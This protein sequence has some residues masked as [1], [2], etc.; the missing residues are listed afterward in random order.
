MLPAV[1]HFCG[2][3]DAGEIC[4][5][6]RLSQFRCKLPPN[7]KPS[8]RWSYLIPSLFPE[9]FILNYPLH[10]RLLITVITRSYRQG[11]CC[12]IQQRLTTSTYRPCIWSFCIC[13]F[14]PT[15]QHGPVTC[16]LTPSR[17][18]R[19][20]SNRFCHPLSCLPC[21]VAPLL[22]STCR[23]ERERTRVKG[24][25]DAIN[26][27]NFCG[28]HYSIEGWEDMSTGKKLLFFSVAFVIYFWLRVCL[29]VCMCVKKNSARQYGIKDKYTNM[30]LNNFT[31]SGWIFFKLEL[32]ICAWHCLFW[33]WNIVHSIIKLGQ[34]SNHHAHIFSAFNVDLSDCFIWF[35]FERL[36]KKKTGWRMQI[37]DWFIVSWLPWLINC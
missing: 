1:S 10:P 13:L 3:A 16:E 8:L 32:H 37:I 2:T 35:S 28:S 7:L 36:T 23:S 9:D 33:S 22:S 27:C 31:F 5:H 25:L 20:P 26:E 17:S 11:L 19:S 29:R 14:P 21:P 18:P 15:E 4:T 6:Q 24:G 30:F 34:K 12:V